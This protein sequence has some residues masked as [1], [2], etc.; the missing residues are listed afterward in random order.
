MRIWRYFPGRFFLFSCF[1]FFFLVLFNFNFY[2]YCHSICWCWYNVV[3]LLWKTV[4]KDL[5]KKQK[6]K[7]VCQNL[8]PLVSFY[9]C[10]RMSYTWWQ[11]HTLWHTRVWVCTH[12][13]IEGG[14]RTWKP[15]VLPE[16]GP[17][18]SK[19]PPIEYDLSKS[20]RLSDI[21]CT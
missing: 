20:L 8:H 4:N 13:T 10:M 14:G 11:T 18:K 17:G 7:Y 1:L 6:K 2:F 21:N 5:S 19:R 9:R 12:T 3:I 16:K 15:W